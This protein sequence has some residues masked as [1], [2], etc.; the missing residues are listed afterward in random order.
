MRKTGSQENV[1]TKKVHLL[2]MRD[3]ISSMILSTYGNFSAVEPSIGVAE[4][5]G[6]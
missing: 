6:E 1:Q 2:A 4:E 5:D 3:S